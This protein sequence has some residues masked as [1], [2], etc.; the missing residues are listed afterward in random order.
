MAALDW[1]VIG[2]FAIALIGVIVWVMRQK[3]NN[4]ADYFLGGKDATWIAI[5]ASIFASNIG[6]EHLIGL[7][8]S[9]A[10]AGMA[11]AHWEIQGWMILLLGWVFVPFYTRSMVYTM[12]EFLERRFNPQSRT[13]LATISLISY[14]LTKVAVTVYA[15]G[16]VFQQVFG[17]EEVWGIDFFWI[18]A[19]GLVLITALYTIFGGMKSVLYT[20][21]LQTPILLLGSLI[22][23][24]LGLKELGGWDEMMRICS[25]VKV[26]EYG[27][28]MV[29]L[30]RDNND[31]QY[32]WL[33]ALI[34][35]AVI[36]FWYWCTDQFIVQRVL[37]GKDEKEARRG[38]I[39]GAYLK[40][41]PVFLFL[42]PGMIAFAIHQ[43]QV[44]A[45]GEG[46]LPMLANGNVNSDAAFPT[47]VAKLLP[48]GVKGLIV[49]GILAAL[50]SS[51]ASLFNS[52]AAL[53]T[54][55]F[56]QR[57][58]PN[59]DPKKLVR[60]GQA[61][62]VVIVILG[63]LWI[64][65]MRSVGD[66]LYLYLQDVQSVLAPGIAAAF[67]IGILWK[68]ATALGGMW[69]LLS[70]LIIGLTRLGAK[71]YYS[72]ATVLPDDNGSMFQYLFYDCNW[73]FFCG[74]MLVFCLAV[75]VIV[76]LCTKAPDP[77][78]IQGLVFGT[79][80]PEQRAATRASWNAWD[81]INS[82]II[83]GITA[84]FYIYFW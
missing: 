64:P 84:A 65:V 46:F 8:G 12:P 17:I 10:S 1:L 73:L 49:C 35:S 33:G 63:I 75:G 50:M 41:L 6:S 26:N 32:P 28:S 3:Q 78:K 14:V 39:F 69:A 57:F 47:L 79:S 68:R 76:S 83:L 37:S 82:I 11:M 36:G 21:V 20:S 43:Q 23:L 9:G 67:L 72:N 7:A 40:L 51:L 22:I 44:T 42:I 18:A 61:A 58:R 81:V 66:V 54:I 74:W 24:V 25:E 60:I 30:I 56:Y 52:S 31:A 80:T 29:N 48:A 77:A 15:G 71:V 53:F 55:D 70:G 19:I 4:A 34:G 5:G 62:T 38:T 13:I 2:I 59:T 27:D 45:G 16:L